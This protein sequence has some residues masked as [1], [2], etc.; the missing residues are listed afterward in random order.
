MVDGR[1]FRRENL[2]AGLNRSRPRPGLYVEGEYPWEWVGGDA[3]AAVVGGD[4][5]ADGL[6]GA[7]VEE[8]DVPEFGG[9]VVGAR[10]VLRELLEGGGGGAFEAADVAV[11]V[12]FDGAEQEVDVGFFDGGGVAVRFYIGPALAGWGV[13]GDGV[14]GGLCARDSWK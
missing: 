10:F 3:A 12:F 5:V 6:E 8:E 4:V 7:G 2:F 13:G 9:P 14:G 11:E 1:D